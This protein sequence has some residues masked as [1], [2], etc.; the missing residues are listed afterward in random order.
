MLL[1]LKS[2]TL[3]RNKRI[4][5]KNFSLKL[6]QSQIIVIKGKNGIGKSSLLEFIVGLAK[7]NSGLKY[8]NFEL[9][10]TNPITKSKVF[11]LGH[12]NS[13]K[14]NFSDFIA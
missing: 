13:L 12:Q 3:K 2:V 9:V 8:S 5:F 1:E 7:Q 10:K 4:L 11:Y 14:D 6:N